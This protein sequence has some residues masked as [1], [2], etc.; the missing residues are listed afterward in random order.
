[1]R[2]KD[3]RQSSNVVDLRDQRERAKHD[4]RVGKEKPGL[5]LPD[6]IMDSILTNEI[7]GSI[8]DPIR[9]HF[10]K[11]RMQGVSPGLDAA[12]NKTQAQIVQEEIRG[13][14]MLLGPRW[15]D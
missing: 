12:R 7:Q 11:L 3:R 8:R 9:T 5:A 6:A 14:E 1:M 10:E 15:K 2:A 4:L 13:M